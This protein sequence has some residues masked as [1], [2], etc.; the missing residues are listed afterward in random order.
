MIVVLYAR[1][2][3][4]EGQMIKDKLGKA[5]PCKVDN[6]MDLQHINL[7]YDSFSTY[8]QR[9]KRPCARFDTFFI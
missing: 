3:S 8:W 1:R 7:L 6:T 4:I 5:L 9:I 2:V